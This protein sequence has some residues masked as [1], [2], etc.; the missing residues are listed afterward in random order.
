MTTTERITKIDKDEPLVSILVLN[1][2][3]KKFLKACF[4]SLKKT[5]YL[6][7]EILFIDNN[8]DDNS[9]TYVRQNYRDVKILQ[10]DR[11]L[12]YSGAYN[13]AF[14]QARGKYFVLLNFDVRVEPN[15]L[16]PLVAAAE[17]DDT[18]A[19]LQ[20]K[21]LS[22]IDE[23]YFEY[24][25][26]SGGFLDRYGYPFL[27]G[28]IFYSIEKDEQQYEDEKNIF[29]ASGAALFL[30]SAVLKESGT[31]DED[32]FLHMEEIDLCWRLHLCGYRLMVIPSA[33][34]YHHVGASLPQGS[35]MK[36]YLNHRNN[37]MMMV[38]NMEGKNLFRILSMRYILDLINIFYAGL[39]KFDFQH[40]Y[41]I[42]KAHIWLIFHLG[43]ILTKRK[44]V[45]KQRKVRDKDYQHLIYQKS[46]VI[47][48]F[49]KRKK[50]YSSLNFG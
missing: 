4:D 21:L 26:A 37:I 44:S 29:W 35:F 27:R 46:L 32:F 20:P 18:I 33:V 15:W 7:F 28:R 22:M 17:R 16:S 8:S 43:M 10:L 39:V 6:N 34:V 45:Q 41:S 31:L 48:Y 50:T 1:Y 42:I 49:V 14:N 3:G 24:T 9:V 2:N 23:G 13:H 19:A 11:N 36:L 40:A 25:G 12:G 30:R 5:S 47:D 38:K